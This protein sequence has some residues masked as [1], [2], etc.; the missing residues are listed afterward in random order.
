MFVGKPRSLPYSG[1][2]ERCFIQVFS[3]LTGPGWIGLLGANALAYYKKST[4]TAVKSFI[5]LAPGLMFV[6]K[7]RSLPYSGAPERCFIQVFSGIIRLGWEGLPGTNDLAY[8][9]KS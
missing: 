1:A 3:G 2:P 5:A 4:I 7:A 8:Y 6:G 9:K